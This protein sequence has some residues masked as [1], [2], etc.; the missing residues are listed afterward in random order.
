[1]KLLALIPVAL[2][3]FGAVPP[4]LAADPRVHSVVF[5]PD[6][7][8][9]FTGQPGY[10]SAIRFGPDER[11]ENV[12]VGDSVAWQVT[13][14]KRG[15]HLFVK[16][17]VAGARS[18]MTVVTTRR[19]YLF[20]LRAPRGAQPVYALSFR[21]PAYPAPGAVQPPP[22][23][24]PV[25]LAALAA[26]PVAPPV[27]NFGWVPKGAKSLRPLR[28]FDDGKSVFLSWPEGLPLPAV[29]V[30]TS[31]KSEGPVNYRV[32]GPYIVVDGL[33]GELILRRGKE[34][35]TVTAP[36]VRTIRTAAT[37]APRAGR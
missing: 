36:K 17:M 20:D 23:E 32:E 18:N 27:L 29:L 15:D 9:T 1:M 3:V 31:D 19:T 21:Y 2:A 26:R 8:V 37:E 28:A 22:P 10:Q 12:A 5:E 24:A 4:A 34:R 13:P 16:P 7:V 6:S 25:A 33:P 11:I 35:A 30:A 14:N